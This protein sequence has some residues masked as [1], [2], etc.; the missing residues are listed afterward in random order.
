MM[1]T[2]LRSLR[3]YLTNLDWDASRRGSLLVV[4][5]EQLTTSPPRPEQDVE[6]E[7]KALAEGA[8][9]F[10]RRIG[11]PGRYGYNPALLEQ[12]FEL[13]RLRTRTCA[14]LAPSLMVIPA[15]RLPKPDFHAEDER[16]ELM[17]LLLRTCTQTQWEKLGSRTGF[18]L[19]DCETRAQRRLFERIVPSPL[20]VGRNY[21]RQPN[22]RLYSPS[23]R[24][25]ARLRV[26]LYVSSDAVGSQGAEAQ[27]LYF[28][29]DKN[30][31]ITLVGDNPYA[32]HD[33]TFGASLTEKVPRKQKPAALSY[34]ALTTPVHLVPTTTVGELVGQIASATRLPLTVDYRLKRHSVLTWGTQ[35]AAGDLLE[36]LCWSLG[37]SVRKLD[38]AAFVLTWDKEPLT[39]HLLRHD[40]WEA[41]AWLESVYGEKEPYKIDNAL[42]YLALADDEPQRFSRSW[43]ERLAGGPRIVKSDALPASVQNLHALALAE[44][45]RDQE[46]PPGLDSVRLVLSAWAQLLLPD[47]PALTLEPL[48]VPLG[49]TSTTQDEPALG[50]EGIGLTLR[51]ETPEQAEQLLALTD[52]LPLARLFLEGDAPTL[53]AALKMTKKPLCGLERLL[54]VPP[55]SDPRVD[56]NILGQSTSEYGKSRGR[57]GSD[58]LIP[59]AP[60]V[61]EHCRSKVQALAA[62]PGLAG[63]RLADDTPPGYDAELSLQGIYSPGDALGY[64]RENRLAYWRETGTDPA[65]IL[66][67]RSRITL[68]YFDEGRGVTVSPTWQGWLRQRVVRLRREATA[69]L[70]LPL[71][72]TELLDIFWLGYG[73]SA[74]TIHLLTTWKPA[75]DKT[76]LVDRGWNEG[77]AAYQKTGQVL[78]F[79]LAVPAPVPASTLQGYLETVRNSAKGMELALDLSSWPVEAVLKLLKSE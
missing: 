69:G 13:R 46:T 34:G 33:T 78:Y 72:R 15:R 17:E 41:D 26:V 36:A 24:L 65:D 32:P 57:R 19:P 63:L 4:A 79:S 55:G 35:V 6:E 16:P 29:G 20:V 3:D 73:H 21:R 50:W 18:G 58:W 64:S 10:A 77:A 11:P 30:T 76:P 53:A 60:G 54:T 68:P 70:T 42:P 14:A 38:P 44:R 40:T 56:R 27:M 23:E 43:V 45:F 39:L 49:A 75:D 67:Y 9:A 47:G 1:Q 5:P 8:A 37:G 22:D 25:R 52:K 28:N 12:A 59:D 51:A 48:S 2:A 62:L 7:K 31:E 71:W 74:P 61:Q 66:G